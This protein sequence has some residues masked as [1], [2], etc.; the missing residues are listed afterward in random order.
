MHAHTIV[1]TTVIASMELATARLD[2]PEKLA[3]RRL[4]P[5]IAVI[6]DTVLVVHAFATHNS[7]DEIAHTPSVQTLALVLEAA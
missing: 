5:Q 3:L 6:K 7:L 2:S 4:A 1:L